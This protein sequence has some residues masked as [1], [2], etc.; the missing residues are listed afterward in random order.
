LAAFYELAGYGGQFLGT[1]TTVRIP[2][3]KTISRNFT[4]RYIPPAIVI[5]KV[6][7]KNVPAGVVISFTLLLACPSAFPYTGTVVPVDCVETSTPL[8]S[9]YSLTTLPPGSWLL[10]PG[11]ATNE[12]E[13]MSDDGVAATLTSNRVTTRNLSVPYQ[14]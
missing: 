14:A 9:D 12:I 8:G 7:V 4:L 5:G 2:A 10:Y 6:N 1:T 13:Y 11:Y 3:G